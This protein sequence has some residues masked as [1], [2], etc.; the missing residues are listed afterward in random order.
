MHF[1][2]HFGLAWKIMTSHSNL[3]PCLHVAG[4]Q[5]QI[6]KAKLVEVVVEKTVVPCKS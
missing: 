4:K 2:E 6:M 5:L 3:F 1:E